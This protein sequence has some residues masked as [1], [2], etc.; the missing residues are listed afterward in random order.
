MNLTQKNVHQ[1]AK[2]RRR[3]VSR[4]RITEKIAAAAPENSVTW[5][6]AMAACHALRSLKINP[7][8]E[9]GRRINNPDSR[10]AA[11]ARAAQAD[12]EIVAL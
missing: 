12:I 1:L 4:G 10:A 5:Q 2:I 3:A 6:A 8:I 11:K 9:A 7:E